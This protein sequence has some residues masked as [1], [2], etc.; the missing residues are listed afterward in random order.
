MLIVPVAAVVESHHTL[1]DRDIG[2]LTRPPGRLE[3][4]CVIQHPRVE[5]AA[6][7]AGRLL[8]IARVDIVGPA[9]EGLD[10]QTPLPERGNQAR[11]NGGLADIRGRAGNDDAGYVARNTWYFA[12]NSI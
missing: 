10:N 3:Q 8:V 2:I 1:Y 9:L 11:C 4:L 7:P 5:I 12:Q 6:R